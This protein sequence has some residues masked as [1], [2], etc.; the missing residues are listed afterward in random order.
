MVSLINV[1]M[2]HEHQEPGRS[3]STLKIVKRIREQ[4]YENITSVHD[5]K[6]LER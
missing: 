1:I 4:K 2:R 3:I 6:S 5:R